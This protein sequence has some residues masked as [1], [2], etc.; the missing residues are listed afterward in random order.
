MTVDKRLEALRRNPKGDWTLSDLQTVAARYNIVWRHSGGSHAVF[1][2]P[3]GTQLTVPARRPI[4][5][6]YVTKFVDLIDEAK[7][8]EP[9]SD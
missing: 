2:A 4:K 8:T 9:P 5:P 1:R 7:Q 3:N 6:I